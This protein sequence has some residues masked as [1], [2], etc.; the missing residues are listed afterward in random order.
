MGEEVKNWGFL[1]L[2]KIA[3][4]ERRDIGQST[5][6]SIVGRNGMCIAMYTEGKNHAVVGR[7]R[8][9]I[10]RTI[11]RLTLRL[12]REWLRLMVQENCISDQPDS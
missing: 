4:K 2:E 10:D 6:R 9:A 7:I 8:R 11:D 5:E 1:L 3:E 12:N